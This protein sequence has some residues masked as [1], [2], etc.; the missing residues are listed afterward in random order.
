MADEPQV[1]LTLMECPIGALTGDPERYS[2]YLATMPKVLGA[3]TQVTV[4]G[5]WRLTV[6]EHGTLFKGVSDG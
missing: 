5:Y 1:T 3:Y 6:A 4:D 2:Y